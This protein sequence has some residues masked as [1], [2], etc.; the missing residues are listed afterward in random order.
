MVSRQ[1][2][3]TRVLIGRQIGLLLVLL[4]V[5]GFTQALVLRQVLYNS[6]A[7]SLQDELSV[8]AP[9][10]H[11]SLAH[12]TFPSLVPI[13]F[14]RFRAPGVEVVLAN[15]AGFAIADS[16]TLPTNVVPPPLPAPGGYLVW[17]NHIVVG[18]TM[19]EHGKLLGTIWLL[20]SISPLTVIIAQ[21]VEL[22]GG[23]ALA[24][25][26]AVAW[27][28]MLSVRRSLK[29]LDAVITTT[30]HIAAGDFGRQADVTNAPEELARLGD[31]VNRMSHAVQNSFAVERHA[32]DEMRRFLADASHELRTPLAAVSGFLDL[33]S[34]GDLTEDES[35]RGLQAMKRETSRMTRIVTQLL[36]LSRLDAAP[37]QEVRPE[38]TAMDHWIQ[39]LEPTLR[40]L[41]GD[42]LQ[43]T[44]RPVDVLADR[45]RLSEVLM[46][47]VDNA[48]RHTPPNGP[49]HLFVG[50]G[51]VGARLVVEDT[52][53]G[54]PEDVLRQ[55]FDRFYRG[56]SARS[57][58]AGGAGLGLAIVKALV[59]AH[60]GQVHAE[61]R[62]EG[63]A[64]FI[65]DL[66][67]PTTAN[68]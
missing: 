31:A 60:G 64:R 57:R 66:P 54:I 28:G 3:L 53:P 58:Q 37:A 10:L 29:P 47:L 20:S 44:V 45:D 17:A 61:N 14:N 15:P 62:P 7:R 34:H 1:A 12:K 5:L 63:G 51:P 21:D 30:E 18:T 39:D 23:L 41:A 43:M 68:T 46:N 25:L 38:P 8:L 26:A 19:H 9:L 50:P 48:L 24:L 4:I 33:W 59:N 49:I 42:R 40:T 22:Y 27:L 11:H 32:Q 52:G 65:V 2:S 55:L 36:T 13:L 35:S 16:P 67:G 6:T 56:D